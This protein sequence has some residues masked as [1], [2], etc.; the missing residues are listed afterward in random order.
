MS[1]ETGTS[2]L[3]SS[4]HVHMSQ[5]LDIITEVQPTLRQLPFDDFV[6]LLSRPLPPGAEADGQLK[7][8]FASFAGTDAVITPASLECVMSSLGQPI[9]KL[10]AR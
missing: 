5:V 3:S 4:N 9:S 6:S 2:L 1:F 8:C 7:E 10:Q